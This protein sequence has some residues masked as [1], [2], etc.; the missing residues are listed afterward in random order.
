MRLHNF[1][2]V[3]GLDA[4]IPNIVG[5]NNYSDAGLA[6][7]EAASLLRADLRLQASV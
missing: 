2:D 7:I 6:N 4:P 1:A 5:V 3:L